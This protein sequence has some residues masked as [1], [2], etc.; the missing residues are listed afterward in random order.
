[1]AVI[2]PKA[3]VIR[4]FLTENA[5]EGL[6]S[7]VLDLEQEFVSATVYAK[8]AAGVDHDKRRC[9]KLSTLGSSL[10]Q[11]FLAA[12]SKRVDSF[13]ADVGMAARPT[14]R[15]ETEIAAYNDGGFFQEH[16]DTLTGSLR[17]EQGTGR[18]RALSAVY[19]FHQEPRSF[20][21][22]ALRL[23]SFGDASER[24]SRDIDPVGNTLVVFPSFASHEVRP[25][26]CPSQKFEDSRFAIN[27][28][29]HCKI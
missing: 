24:E 12:F 25:V 11:P 23:W 19:Y 3:L 6:L 21:G 2:V 5:R 4:Q 1:M 28:W 18:A 17:S 29:V 13:Y 26:Q 7:S 27:C 22:G 16:V 10:L 15:F 14:A 9:R 20:S 8:S